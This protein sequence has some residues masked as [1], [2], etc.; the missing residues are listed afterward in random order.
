MMLLTTKNFGKN[1]KALFG[2]KMT[3]VEKNNLITDDKIFAKTFNEI[4]V[5]IVSLD[6]NQKNN[7]SNHDN[8]ILIS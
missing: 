6:I 5:N 2:N 1:V 8:I 3:L 4:L 7:V